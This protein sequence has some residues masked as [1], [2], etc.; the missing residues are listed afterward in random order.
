MFCSYQSLSPCSL[1][2]RSLQIGYTN[3]DF[4]LVDS[5]GECGLWKREG[6]AF[7]DYTCGFEVGDA[8]FGA[9]SHEDGFGEE[10]DQGA[11]VFRKP[12]AGG[13]IPIDDEAVGGVAFWADQLG[14][15]RAGK[16]AAG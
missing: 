7:D 5:G 16:G 11:G 4:A 14:F 10:L 9:V 3:F 13:L 2:R 6:H 12:S 15:E 8:V 1:L